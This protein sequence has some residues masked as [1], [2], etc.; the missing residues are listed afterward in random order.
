[1]LF[2]TSVRFE[3]LSEI[4]ERFRAG[5]IPI[6]VEPDYSQ[7]DKLAI[8]Y[9]SAYTSATSPTEWYRINIS[10]DEQFDEAKLL[11]VDSKY[12]VKA[13]VDID[14]FEDKLKKL[15]VQEVS[16]I[17]PDNYLNR[18]A[19]IVFVVLLIGILYAVMP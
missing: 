8:G 15:A 4:E 16:L 1:M 7:R 17:N 18:I 11:F 3:D 9:A 13:P 14:E 19:I 10:L 6:Y 2:L 12:K 5:G